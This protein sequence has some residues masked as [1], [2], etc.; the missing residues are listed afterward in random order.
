MK[1]I[2]FLLIGVFVSVALHAETIEVKVD[3]LTYSCDTE[4]QKATLT[5][6]TTIIAEV[7]IPD[8]ITVSGTEYSV[9]SI[10]QNAFNGNKLLKGLTIPEGIS[11]IGIDAFKDCYNLRKVVLPS[12]VESI[13]GGAFKCSSLDHIYCKIETPLSINVNVFANYNATLYVPSGKSGTYQGADN[14]K[15]FHILEG[16]MKEIQYGGMTYL[17]ASVSHKATLYAGKNDA[18]VQIVSSFDADDGSYSVTAIGRSAFAGMTNLTTL[19]IPEGIEVIGNDAFNGCNNLRIVELPSTLSTIGENAFKCNNLNHIY[20]KIVDPS[21]FFYTVFSK[22][23][24]SLYVPVGYK[25]NYTS[26]EGWNSFTNIYEGDMKEWS[27]D[28]LTYIC[29]KSTVNTATL[30]KGAVSLKSAPIPSTITVDGDDYSVTRIGE[31]AFQGCSIM[32]TVDL[33]SSLVNIGANA[34]NGCNGLKYIVSR[35]E[36]ENLF[37]IEDNVFPSPTAPTTFTTML[38]VPENATY[39]YSVKYGWSKFNFVFEGEKMQM[40]DQDNNIYV[41]GS[42]SSHAILISST[43]TNSDVTIP[44]QL[45]NYTYTV[46]AIDK[47]AFRYNQKIVNLTIESGI[48]SIG[49]SAFEGCSLLQKINLPSSINQ[50]GEKAFYGCTKIQN[51]VSEGYY[52]PSINNNVFSPS[53][54]TSATLYVPIGYIDFYTQRGWNFTSFLEGE[55]KEYTDPTTKMTYTYATGSNVATLKQSTSEA[56]NVTILSTI[57]IDGKTYTVT[58]IDKSAFLNNGYLVNLTIA[59]DIQVIGESAFQGCSK[60][61]KVKLPKNLTKMGASA[62]SGCKSLAHVC[63]QVNTPLIIDTTVFP[64][65][66]TTGTKTLYVPK[67]TTDAY[68]NK[69]GWG[70]KFS[71]IWEG[72]MKEQKDNDTGLTYICATDSR[73]AILVKGNQSATDVIVLD[74]VSLGGQKYH[75]ATIDKAAFSGASSLVNLTIQNTETINVNAFKGC[76]SL[77]KLVF[78]KD[79]KDLYISDDAFSSCNKLVHVTNHAKT[80]SNI[81]TTAFPANNTATL[82]VPTGSTEK[83]R[84]ADGWKDFKTILEGDMKEWTDG[85][86]D[87]ICIKTD[88]TA[89]ATLIK[90]NPSVIN[91]DVAIPD[92]I[93]VDGVRYG[94]TAIR[95]SAFQNCTK[96]RKIELSSTIKEI[97]DYAFDG[98]SALAYIVSKMAVP[99][100]MSGNVFS[101]S[102]AMLF[103]PENTTDKYKVADGWSKF[104]DNILEG[105]MREET[106]E[107]ITY[108]CATVSKSATL[109]S[110]ATDL[111]TATIPLSI[112]CGD[113]KCDVVSIGASAFKKCTALQEIELPSS[114]IKI[115][116]NAFSDCTNL[117][118]ITSKINVPRGVSNVFPSSIASTAELYVPVGTKALYQDA[119]G[120]KMF[121][122]IYEGVTKEV[123][124]NGMTYVIV[125]GAKIA[126]LISA[127]TAD[128]DVIVPSKIIVEKDTFQ[129]TA[130]DKNAFLGL[131]TLKNLTIQEGVQTIG[132]DAFTDCINLQ[133]IDLPSSLTQIDDYAFNK[134]NSILN[135]VSRLNDPFKISENVFSSYTATVYVPKNTTAKYKDTQGW[136]N[137]T[138][139]LEG[140]IKEFTDENGMTYRCATASE[141]AILIKTTSNA[142][143]VTIPSTIKVEDVTYV[144]TAI[145]KAV[146]KGNNSLWNLTIGDNIQIIGENAFQYCQNLEKVVLPKN[147]KEIGAYAFDGC[148][149]LS[150]VCSKAGTPFTIDDTVFPTL[151]ITGSKT[152]YVPFST[153]EDYKNKAGW[154]D[155]F[156]AIWEGEMMEYTD[157]YGLTYICATESHI[158][159]LVKGN[160]TDTEVIVPT[161][162][163]IN[164]TLYDIV[165]IG[166]AAF[167]GATNLVNLT[168]EDVNSIEENAFQGCTKL[169]NLIFRYD[170]YNQQIG[171]KAFE[172]CNNLVHVVNHSRYPANISETAFSSY[173]ASLYVP[174][175]ATERYKSALGW[176]NF[177]TIYEGDMKE[178][179]DGGLNYICLKGDKTATAMLIGADPNISGDI[180]IPATIKIDDINYSVTTIVES[181]FKDCTKLRKIELPSTIN[182]IGDYA[183]DGC[184]SLAYIVSKMAEPCIIS[185]N[186]FSV[187]TAMLFVPKGTTDKYKTTSG[188]S[189]F[190]NS[191]YEGDMKEEILDNMTYVCA[192]GTKTATLIKGATTLTSAIIPGTIPCDTITCKVVAIGANAFQD[193]TKLEVIDLPS[194]LIQ[195][196]DYAFDGCTGLVHINSRISE[197]FDISENVFSSSTIANAKLYVPIGTNERYLKAKGWKEFKNLL[198]GEMKEV[199]QNDMT[200]TCVTGSKTATLIKS[201]TTLTDVIV[202][203]SIV[204]DKDTFLV[205]AIDKSAFSGLKAM[206]NLTIQEGIKTIGDNAFQN[207][208]GLTNIELPSTIS[209][210]GEYAFDNC[211]SILYIVSRIKEPTTIKDNVFS[212]STATLFVPQGATATYR[213][214]DGWSKFSLVFE[215]EKKEVTVDDMSYVY[216]TV[217]KTAI[218]VKTTTTETDVTIPA[219]FKDGEVTYKVTVIDKEVFKGHN[220]VSLTIKDNITTIGAGAFQNCYKLQKIELPS[221][222]TKIDEKAFSGCNNIQNIVSKIKEPVEFNENVFTNYTATL[223]V[224]EKTTEKYQKT[225]GWKNFKSFL[226]GEMKEFTDEAGM[227]FTYA[228]GSKTAILVKSTSTAK[229]IIIPATI[230]VDSVT[231]KVTTIGKSAFSDLKSMTN[232]TIQEGIQI[233]GEGAFQN[234]TNLE[235]VELPATLTAI[236]DNAFYNC[237]RLS[238]II[239]KLNEPLSVSNNIFSESTFATATLYVPTNCMSLYRSASVWTDFATI[240]EGEMN[241][242][243][244]D[245]M[246]FYYVTGPNIA[247]LAKAATTTSDVTVPDT[248]SVGNII[249]KVTAIDKYAFSG[250]NSLVN[251]TIAEG[252]ITIGSNAFQNCNN[253]QRVTLPSSLTQIGDYAFDKCSR[254]TYVS[255]KV[256]TPFVISDN[257]FTTYTAKLNVPTG[258]ATSYQKTDGWKN[259]SIVLEGELKDVV[260]DGMTY[261]YATG[262]RSASLAKGVTNEKDVTIP[263]TITVNEITYTVTDI[264]PSAFNNASSLVNLTISE[265]IQT[266]GA[267]AFYNCAFLNKIQLPSTIIAIGEGAFNKCDRI[268]HVESLIK[269]PSII[270]DN[271]FTTTTYSEATLYVP[272]SAS[273]I[274]K[275]TTG[276]KNFASILEGEIM[277][278]TVDGMKYICV[279][280]LKI[281]KLVQGSSNSKEVTVPSSIKVD[282]VNYDVTDIDRS[283]FYGS[284][285]LVNLTISEGIKK[286]GMMA[287]KNCYNLTKVI[288]PAS[289]TSIGDNAFDTCN[290]LEEVYSNIQT[291]F[292][293]SDNVFSNYS[294]NLHVPEGTDSLY[295]NTAGWSNFT[296]VKLTSPITIGANGKT[297]YCGDKDLDFSFS[298][299]VKAFIATG[300]DKDESIIWMTRVKDVPAGVPV[301]IKGEANKTY[302]IPISNG[303][304][305]YYKNMFV[306][307]TKGESISIGETSEDGKYVNYYMSGGQFKSVKTSANIGANKCY[308][309]L[310][311]TFEAASEGETLSVKIAAS[312]KSSFAAPCDLDFTDFGDELK[313]FTATGYD[314]STKTIWLTRVKKVQ[315][316]EGLLL[317]GTGGKT[318]EI[319]SSGIQANYKNMFVGNIS[320]ETLEIG[321]KSADGTLTNYYLK[322]GTYV[323]VSGTANIGTNK[324]Y[325]QLPT[326][327]L[328]GARSE[329]PGELDILENL[330][331]LG[332]PNTYQFAELDTEAMPIV[333]GSIGDND[334]DTTGN[335]SPTLSDEEDIWYSLNGQR[336][337]KPTKKGLYIKNGRKVVIK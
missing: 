131:R 288:L 61:E 4:T 312:G 26:K 133:T 176:K 205:T 101:V 238:H 123:P 142:K 111:T 95:E 187:S 325:L 310:P 190:S 41:Y 48:E 77:R 11:S 59:D 168:L 69:S 162:I 108:V 317:K 94:V 266:I 247:T 73:I 313:A 79:I 222:L 75:V 316:G 154:G 60:L 296:V 8:K 103:V 292:V 177:T 22:T 150:H 151:T 246:T 211:N 221:S 186:V 18:G 51:I 36:S 182:E 33:P 286:I 239:N 303:G 210:I 244:I 78:E 332:I 291:P 134:C 135:I 284:N 298:D 294:A 320:G 140:E 87:Y 136:S 90:A 282:D 216:A 218:L 114:L 208:I 19:T 92:T 143:E 308:L 185:G 280:N 183:F 14:W 74:S 115:G 42:V 262:T 129:V 130:I 166:K 173:T 195:I 264:D 10:G 224:P 32:E 21:S 240:L 257:V 113:L 299:E 258:S 37:E 196:D 174:T 47:I 307:N 155:K 306:G 204:V 209:Q 207:C 157:E 237:S 65:I 15:N 54:Y 283:A 169:R 117:K 125:T 70:D 89:T 66:S 146:F 172:K 198:Q 251:L 275:G 248:I 63:S 110:A 20:S 91:G 97:G 270:K 86:L 215:G 5:K 333:F 260:I 335:L 62:F 305:S 127:T 116:E 263:S 165:T 217:S 193:C 102:S 43:T 272:V 6:S 180:A 192:T 25:D 199:T 256:A 278:A 214:T 13:G 194:S 147:L 229:D 261:T 203:S 329:A 181:A 100:T 31:N 145:D 85:G 319:P 323:S 200:Y 141:T 273:S 158:A 49:A 293:I 245:G 230:K 88:D 170:T 285:S 253:M 148:N 311:A 119:E 254:L 295:K 132:R 322:G 98:C 38:F 144:V 234:C 149:H 297:T 265:G 16:E 122:K 120:W 82:Y 137:F 96:L 271:V 118:K 124:L 164:A 24:A 53:T 126:T 220:M 188:W 304:V 80:P 219:T 58:T 76:T 259:F 201:T 139:F 67:N 153:S 276:W 93:T 231:Y 328:T 163:Y 178:W 106:L 121:D 277:E 46:K 167:S 202:P 267:N 326:S 236:G 2:L 331:D 223:Y 109:V 99:C 64:D 250:I 290:R 39:T 315:K 23:S 252:I 68:K 226:E 45:K 72:E 330:R 128:A 249:Y 81:S 232:L 314:K 289:L 302:D 324:S 105:D 50:I 56:E 241:I 9:V 318:Y 274:Y 242:K 309:Q 152:L 213:K 175:G 279:P 44:Y 268:S 112:P 228:T 233:I 171:D 34:F 35:I 156:S 301:M 179:S 107:K 12:T 227:T 83:Y 138:S 55:M 255:C 159:I 84:S 327:M 225:N 1:R 184:S 197:P 161:S 206:T 29:V 337:S 243:T 189:K 57:S 235:K 17:C 191:I 40:E 28:G 30:T 160:K 27:K 281:A 7:T 71:A 300:Y 212:I 334:D 321:E 104:K 52:P 269:A 3:S 336:I 287:F